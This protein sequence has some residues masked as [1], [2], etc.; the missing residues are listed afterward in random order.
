MRRGAA[1]LLGVIGL[2]TVLAATFA[3]PAAAV[4]NNLGIEWTPRTPQPGETVRFAADDEGHWTEFAWDTDND[5]V[6]GNGFGREIEVIYSAPGNYR[7]AVRASDGLGGTKDGVGTVEVRNPPVPP[8]AS[9]VFFPTAPVAGEPVTF[10]STSTDPDSVLSASSLHWDLNGDGAFD[11]AT[12]SSASVTFP[13]PGNYKVG[14]QV[15]TNA[16]DV[17]SIV[18]AVGAPPP[19]VQT[20]HAIYPLMS[21]FPVVRI[22]G[23]TSRRG[24]RIRRLT[25]DAPPGAGV[26]VRCKGRGCPFKAAKR[27]V[28]TRALSGRGLPPT[29]VTRIRRLEGHMLRTGAIVKVLVTRS[30]AVGKYTRFR[31]RRNKPPVRSDYCLVPFSTQPVPCPAR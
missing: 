7:I 1:G 20:R 24:A 10:V 13:V 18:L 6:F 14:L 26:S 31:I 9:F 3:P 17:A 5:G 16:T 2:L 23:R 29:R 28:S 8:Q 27:M 30:D 12:G 19:G 22:A 15:R 25:I 4:P 21:P 11:E